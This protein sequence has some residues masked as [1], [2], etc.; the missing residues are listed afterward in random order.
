VNV[1]ALPVLVLVMSRFGPRDIGAL[2]G[3]GLLLTVLANASHGPVPI[4]LN[5]R[6]PTR[7]RATATA[8]VWNGGFAI[9][10]LM[11]TFVSLASPRLADIPSRLAVFLVG[12]VALFLL[13][14]ALS[15]ETRGALQRRAGNASSRADTAPAQP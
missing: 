6:F 2:L 4:Y 11:T 12:C 3:Y 1:A 9:G 15:P 13:G 14:A 8:V 5:E 10:G 7:L